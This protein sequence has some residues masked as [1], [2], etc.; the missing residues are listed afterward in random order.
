MEADDVAA[1]EARIDAERTARRAHDAVGA[2]PEGE[3]ALFELVAL[4]G[5]T[6][7]EAARALG[8]RAAT[9]RMRLTRARRKLRRLLTPTELSPTVTTEDVHT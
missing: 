5:L 1:I 9:A 6:P 2:L 4:E 3:R 7:S 8:L